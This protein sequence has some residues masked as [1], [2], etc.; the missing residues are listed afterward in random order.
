MPLIELRPF[1]ELLE[2]TRDV[3]AGFEMLERLR[4]DARA[5]S[6]LVSARRFLADAEIFLAA[7]GDVPSP[8]IDQPLPEAMIEVTAEALRMGHQICATTGG[9][10][11]SALVHYAALLRNAASLYAQG[12]RRLAAE[13]LRQ[14]EL[15]RH[16]LKA[17]PAMAVR[18]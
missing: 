10:G 15:S 6:L 14:L 18:R 7:E 1:S 16:E 11:S 4:R 17:L 9:P 2:D 13:T 3:V 12:Q 8:V 5:T